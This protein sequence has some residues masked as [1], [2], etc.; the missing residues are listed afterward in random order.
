MLR[1]IY[2]VPNI[3]SKLEQ[4]GRGYLWGNTDIN[5]QTIE[6]YMDKCRTTKILIKTWK[7]L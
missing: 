6:A 3:Q 2:I 5:N 1:K 7:P 4:N